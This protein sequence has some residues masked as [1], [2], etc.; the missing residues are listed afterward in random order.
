MKILW[1]TNI[2]LPKIAAHLGI[3]PSFLGGWL[4][5][6]SDALLKE[7]S[8]Q[9]AVCFPSFDHQFHQGTIENLTYYAFPQK[10][11]NPIYYDSSVEVYLKKIIEDFKPNLVHIFGT[12]FPHTLSLV[13][14]F[15][16]PD[17][18]IINIQG[19]TSFCAPL[20]SVGVPNHVRYGYSFR[21]LVKMDPLVHQE[22]GFAKRGIYEIDALKQVNH[23]IGRTEWDKAATYLI[24][25]I[26]NYYHLNETL[27]S[28]FYE[29]SWHLDK[30]DRHSIFISQ[31]HYPLKGIHFLIP[32]LPN[33]GAKYPDLKIYV[34]GHPLFRGKTFKDEMKQSHYAHY[35]KKLIRKHQ[36]EDKFV[37]LGNL[38]EV[39]MRH[40]YQKSHVFL[41]LSTLENESNS[42]SEAKMVGCP[43]IASYVGGVTQ[44]IEHGIDGY[45][46]P[47]NETYMIDYYIQQIFDHDEIA[48]SL[49]NR[50]RQAA[51][52]LHDREE[53]CQAL[54]DI[55]HKVHAQSK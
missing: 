39:D 43:A 1:K 24:N 27:R 33:L 16:N 46:Y 25:P 42:L 41:S 30:I 48:L 21:D 5:G 12:E 47:L 40:Q 53:N 38:N 45:L 23:C 54:M 9:L 7:N 19:L 4:V 51:R 36:V 49:S 35:I 2:I 26:R 28:S 14:M 10:K 17:K 18:T 52:K 37:F 15:N 22:K 29:A 13:K 8:V 20:Y 50:A 6:L 55:Y 3:E 31:A 44:R 11:L 32:R 34:A